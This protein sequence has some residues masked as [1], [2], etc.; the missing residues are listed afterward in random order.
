MP[1]AE[2]IPEKP[3]D[4]LQPPALQADMLESQG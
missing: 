4:I 2:N 3:H 1:E